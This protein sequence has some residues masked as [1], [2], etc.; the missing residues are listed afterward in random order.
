[1][2][3]LNQGL[4][5]Y[6]LDI[7]SNGLS[8]SYHEACEISIIRCSDR[9]QLTLFIKVDYPERSSIDALKITGKTLEDLEQGISKEETALKI[10]KFLNEDCLTPA[11]RCLIAHN[12]SFDRRF[13]HAMYSK[14]NKQLPVNLW[15]CSMAL[16]K[17]YAKD[18]GIIKPKVNLQASCDL[19]QI[20]KVAGIHASKADSRN[21]YLLWKALVDD[22]KV[23]YLPF[24]KTAPHNLIEKNIEDLDEGGLDISLLE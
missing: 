10:D 16:T 21:G 4:Q 19:L 9:V 17:Q 5:F 7:E 12:A 8:S 3:E 15:A 13:I 14:V 11:H 20:K 22:K 23:D 18:N 1:M 24:I 6:Y 2:S